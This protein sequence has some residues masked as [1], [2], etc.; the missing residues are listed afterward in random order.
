MT[1]YSRKRPAKGPSKSQGFG[2]VTKLVTAGVSTATAPVALI[3]ILVSTYYASNTSALIASL[4]NFAGT[5]SIISPLIAYLISHIHQ[6]LGFLA[7]SGAALSASSRQTALTVVLGAAVLA[8]W[9]LLPNTSIWQYSL[10]GV[11]TSLFLRFKD[12]KSR[13][14]IGGFLILSL[15]YGFLTFKL[16]PSFLAAT[17][18]TQ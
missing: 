11:L 18:S 9:V 6:F 8:F 14:L 10:L 12:D 16:D 5:G 15:L 13:L 3:A 2:T 7:L 4:N 1:N 17:N